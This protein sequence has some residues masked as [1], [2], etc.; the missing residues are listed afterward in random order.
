MPQLT[1]PANL[2]PAP[3]TGDRA[4]L[5]DTTLRQAVRVTTGGHRIRLRFSHVHGDTPLPLTAVTVALPSD[6]QA[7]V[8]AIEPGS[9]RR[10]AFAGRDAATVPVGAQ[11]VSD[12]LDFDVRAGSDLTVTACAAL[13]PPG[14]LDPL[15]DR[16]TGPDRLR[17]GGT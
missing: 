9:L 11:L 12:P 2:P 1:E 16:R 13:D 3:F 6:G 4:V 15:P 7:G 17:P 8:C 5:A 14:A 10:V